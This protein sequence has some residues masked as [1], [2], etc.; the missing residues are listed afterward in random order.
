MS[1]STAYINFEI[2]DYRDELSLSSYALP[3]TPLRCVPDLSNTAEHRVVWDFGDG[4]ISKSFSAS[5]SYNFPGTYNIALVVYDCNNNAMVSTVQKTVVIYDYIPYTFDIQINDYSMTMDGN[6]QVDENGDRILL[7]TTVNNL[8]IYNGKI[9]GPFVI[10]SYF[11]PYQTPSN[12][13]YTVSNSGSKNYWDIADN[14]YAHLDN[15]YSFYE[16]VYNF[17]IKSYQY[18]EIDKIV[19][20]PIEKYG[21]ISSGNIV[22]CLPDDTGSC[23]LGSIGTND[24]YFKDDSISE[25]L[26]IKFYFDKNNNIIN[27][28]PV[29]H[30]NNLAL[31]LSATIVENI[32]A[33]HLSITSNGLDGEG[34]PI[35]SFNINKIKFFDTKI[36]FVVKIKDVDDFSVKN[37]D[38]INLSALNISVVADYVTLIDTVDYVT[39]SLNHTLSAQNSGGAFRG[40]ITF[41]LSSYEVLNNVVISASGTFTSETLSTYT[42]YGS[43]TQFDVYNKNYYD[44]F[45]VNEDFN[46]KNTLMDLRFQETLL[47]KNVLFEDFLGNLLGDETSTHEAIGVKI[48]EKISNFVSNTQDLDS[49]EQEYIDSLAEMVGYNDSGEE[50]YRYP[51][52]LKRVMNLASLDKSKIVGELNKFKEN[53]DIRGHTSKTEYGINI[54]DRI[55]PQTY[56]IDP[57]KPIVALEKF[58]NTYTVLNTYPLNF[59]Y[60][61]PLLTENL[62][63]LTNES[64]TT[65]SVDV[66][67][68]IYRL[69]AYSSDWGWPLVL[70][71]EFDFAD[72]E[73]YYLFFEYNEEY[74]HTSI[75]GIVDFNN[76]KTRIS[77]SATNSQLFGNNGVFENIFLDTM[78][79]SLSLI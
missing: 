30:L 20:G 27:G 46:P 12:I 51:E 6:F 75:G 5:K 44:A 10:T 34:Y 39:Y 50:K 9:H 42:L 14:H 15:F 61:E 31:T 35:D 64:G 8:S 62:L 11:P 16:R 23:L 43:S 68:P 3:I 24:A 45:K 25:S 56:I 60:G 1:K 66:A 17:Y 53:L 33:D 47:D 22:E 41:P 69:S 40:Y 37:F 73:K 49:C 71:S 21:K 38:P 19:T 54:G 7:S 67:N 4:T 2:Y 63:E 76:P 58:S 70:P 59:I 48:Y 78:Y 52:R 32:S 13:Y 36:P 55:D 79:Q 28:S 57:E 65:L 29:R 26:M 77:L 74:D 72:I 18:Q